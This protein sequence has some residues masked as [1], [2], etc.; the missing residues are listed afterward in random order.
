MSSYAISGM[1]LNDHVS[2]EKVSSGLVIWKQLI[3]YINHCIF[4]KYAPHYI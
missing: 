1:L 3:S 4:V 2:S